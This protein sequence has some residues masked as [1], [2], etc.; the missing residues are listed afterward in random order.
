MGN[1]FAILIPLALE[2]DALGEVPRPADQRQ[3]AQ[4]FLPKDLRPL[5]GLQE[6]NFLKPMQNSNQVC[7]MYH[8]YFQC[9]TKE[10]MKG[11]LILS[12]S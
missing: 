4:A 12:N 10:E 9:K 11:H 5:G 7:H 3:I 6:N 2:E 1:D 8:S